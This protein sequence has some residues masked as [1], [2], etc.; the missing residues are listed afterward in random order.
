MRIFLHGRAKVRVG[1]RLGL[2]TCAWVIGLAACTSGS[3][4]NNVGHTADAGISEST[5][6][7]LECLD[8]PAERRLSDL[9]A[10]ELEAAC[11]GYRNCATATEFS[12]EE[13]CRVQSVVAATFADPPTSNEDELQAVC[14]SAYDQCLQ[15]PAD[16]VAAI[17][18]LRERART[19]PCGAPTQ[20]DASALQMA[21][22]AADLRAQA[23]VAYPTCQELTAD[24]DGRGTS[25]ASCEAMGGDCMDL[26]T[27]PSAD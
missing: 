25:P 15:A 2:G 18:Q 11:R 9:S 26:L 12:V 10:Q 5:E 27:I 22:C 24:F 17:E 19:A 4:D 23:R 3:A 8:L 13:A 16:A 1:H 7:L 21:Q 6:A 14:Q 20:C